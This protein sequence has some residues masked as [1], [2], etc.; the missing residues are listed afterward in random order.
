MTKSEKELLSPELYSFLKKEGIIKQ[1][2]INARNREA[3]GCFATGSK[4]NCIDDA[5]LFQKTINPLD[6]I[7]YYKKFQKYNN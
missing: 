1:F 5:F 7:Y 2:T 3:L 4:I 6:W